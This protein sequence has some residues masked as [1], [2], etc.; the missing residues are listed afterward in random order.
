[1]MTIS[2]RHNTRPFAWLFRV[3]L[4]EGPGLLLSRL[5][6]MISIAL[7]SCF[8]RMLGQC[9]PSKTADGDNDRK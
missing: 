6:T 3:L 5:M 7:S 9:Y 4:C 8:S 2:G 1:M